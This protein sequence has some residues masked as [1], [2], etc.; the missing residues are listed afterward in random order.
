M[1]KLV[2]A[3][4]FCCTFSFAQSANTY[5]E[6]I[7][8]VP[9]LSEWKVY[10]ISRQLACLDGLRYLGYFKEGSC[11]LL[12]VDAEKINDPAIITT[13]IKHLNEKMKIKAM[14]G[15]TI[16]ELLDSAS[17]KTWLKEKALAQQ[18]NTN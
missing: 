8:Q 3:F 13:T 18:L 14:N 17:P 6:L 1:L 7:V 12:H 9:D 10:K 2:F 4:M 15:F 5:K 16:Y 11:L